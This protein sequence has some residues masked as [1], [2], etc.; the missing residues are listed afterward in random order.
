YSIPTYIKSHV[1]RDNIDVRKGEMLLLP[2][3]RLPTLVHS[4][5]G[6]AKWLYEISHKNPV[7]M[8]TEDARRMGLDTGSLVKVATS[9]GYFID[10]VWV[11]EA[12]RPGVVACS[13]HLGRWRLQEESG[14]RWSSALVELG[15][16]APGQWR[17]RQIHGIQPFASSDR[18]SARI[19]W[20]DAGVHQNLIFP[21]QPDP[22]SGQ[23]CWHQKVTV[24]PAGPEDRYGDIFVDTNKAHEEYRRWLAMTRPAPGP[25]GLRRP[26]W[27]VRVYR[28]DASMFYLTER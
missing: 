21:V 19:H 9:I 10:R 17:M 23:H 1:H 26:L 16:V 2:T 3:F 15:Q 11:T 12:I 4:R 25:G 20:E 28:P 18:D 5:S 24:T 27:M 14:G 6:N 13:H 22:I 8:H 7:W